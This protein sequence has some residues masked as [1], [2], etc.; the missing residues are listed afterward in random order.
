[1][2][3][4]RRQVT[5]KIST[6]TRKEKP[7]LL[8]AGGIGSGTAALEIRMLPQK[9]KAALQYG[10]AVPLLVRCSREEVSMQQRL[11]RSSCVA[12]LF[13]LYSQGENQPRIPSI[14][15]VHVKENKTCRAVD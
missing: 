12:V 6:R 3:V 10:P 11:Y 4:S 2:A 9:A 15:Y 1:M 7:A 13:V 8:I 14:E 5:T